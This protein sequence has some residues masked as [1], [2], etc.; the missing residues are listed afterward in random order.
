MASKN[1]MKLLSD[2]MGYHQNPIIDNFG[3]TWEKKVIQNMGSVYSAGGKSANATI[4][5][6]LVRALLS[7]IQIPGQNIS[8]YKEEKC[9]VVYDRKKSYCERT[10]KDENGEDV[11]EI[12]I[13][14]KGRAYIS[15]K[16][17]EYNPK[18][19]TCSKIS[20]LSAGVLQTLLPFFLEDQETLNCYQ[21]LK[22]LGFGTN[23]C[24]YED[25]E[26]PLATLSDNIYFRLK[27]EVMNVKLE[28]IKSFTQTELEVGVIPPT[29]YV[30]TY[31]NKDF[32]VFT[33]NGFVQKS[34]SKKVPKI[35][36]RKEFLEVYKDFGADVPTEQKS[37]VYDLPEYYEPDRLDTKMLR[38]IVESSKMKK[39]HRNFLLQ[40]PPGGGKTLKGKAISAALGLPLYH[41]NFGPDT[42]FFGAVGTVLPATDGVADMSPEEFWESAD[43]PTPDEVM[44]SPEDSYRRLTGEEMP[45][46]MSEE[47]VMTFLFEKQK[48]I[49]FEMVRNTKNEKEFIYEPT[50]L[51]KG[52]TT[53]SVVV[54]DEIANVRDSGVLTAIN[55]FLEGGD[56]VLPTGQ[57]VKRHPDSIIIFTTNVETVSAN[58]IDQSVLSR[59]SAERY[60]VDLPSDEEVLSRLKKTTGFADDEVLK[61]IIETQH[62]VETFLKSK[63]CF[64]GVCGYREIEGWVEN[65]I[66]DE[67]IIQAAESFVNS[68]TNVEQYK[69]EIYEMIESMPAFDVEL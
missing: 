35:L 58:E 20:H 21:T 13:A 15:I 61:A 46:G 54:I 9:K 5:V 11:I 64:D 33:E 43:L 68:A 19:K 24:R 18:T 39:P 25:C 16:A 45:A 8:G 57:I 59:V 66:L 27:D 51:I 10:K 41:M 36:T 63:R 31:G 52:G 47:E 50:P 4:G 62:K 49:S 23:D 28:T 37:L 26:L 2:I 42:D 53:K 22:K 29:S 48:E 12:C 69:D 7:F 3:N 30:T 67:D 14:S 40:G 38:H 55:S 17:G 44:F 65:I 6:G 32:E 56:L 34:V 60:C 1:T